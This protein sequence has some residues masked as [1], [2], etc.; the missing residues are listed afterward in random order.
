MLEVDRGQR[1]Q[2]SN[3]IGAHCSPSQL[4]KSEMFIFNSP[5]KMVAPLAIRAPMYHMP[6]AHLASVLY[7]LALIWKEKYKKKKNLF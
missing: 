6:I 4:A 5:Q 7:L 3:F 2:V 1:T